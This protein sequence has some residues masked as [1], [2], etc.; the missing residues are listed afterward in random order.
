MMTTPITGN[1]EPLIKKLLPQ[2]NT[3]TLPQY[4]VYTKSVPVFYMFVQADGQRPTSS[5]RMKEEAAEESQQSA[6]DN[7]PEVLHKNGILIQWN[8][9]IGMTEV[10]RG[11]RTPIP[12]GLTLPEPGKRPHPNHI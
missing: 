5:I 2:T 4:T 1:R 7:N 12:D 10:R 8:P 11:Y 9:D 6:T 3:N